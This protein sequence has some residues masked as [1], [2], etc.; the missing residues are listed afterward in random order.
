M[1]YNTE[2]ELV[3]LFS[4]IR[5]FLL[6]ICV[7]IFCYVMKLPWVIV[8]HFQQNQQKEPVENI[9]PSSETIQYK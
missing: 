4:D 6:I 3:K 7:L 9:C 5:S 2:Q 8:E 1:H